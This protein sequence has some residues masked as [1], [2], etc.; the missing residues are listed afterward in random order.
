M[1]AT[2]RRAW[3]LAL[4]MCVLLPLGC[5]PRM[6]SL[7]KISMPDVRMPSLPSIG[8][9]GEKDDRV[10]ADVSRGV[11]VISGESEVGV[12]HARVSSFYEQLANRRFN[13]IITY[14]D[15]AL[16]AYFRD[17]DEFS[18]YYADFSHALERAH[19]EKSRPLSLR[20][21]EFSLEE[22]GVASV[23]VLLIGDNNLPLRYGET[24]M[25]RTDRWERH[26]GSWW[27]VPGKF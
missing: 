27:L 13:S 16:R 10:P 6:P 14:R 25:S 12:F 21:E 2:A 19:F 5:A 23:Q 17:D 20:V 3:R 1:A 8:W 22:D 26:D 24:D 15:D 18:D 7:P 9:F 11:Q 4:G